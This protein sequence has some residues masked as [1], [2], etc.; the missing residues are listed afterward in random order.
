MV[1]RAFAKA[2]LLVLEEIA[3]TASIS[4]E[5]AWYAVLERVA[6]P[7]PAGMNVYALAEEGKEAA[8]RLP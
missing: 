2:D 6:A 5:R 8:T 7:A 1:L 3:A 4:L